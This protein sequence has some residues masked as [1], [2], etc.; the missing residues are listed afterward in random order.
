MRDL[1]VVLLHSL[2]VLGP[3]VCQ[4]LIQQVEFGWLESGKEGF[5]HRLL[6]ARTF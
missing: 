5:D 3:P 4:H 6:N 2:R 1:I